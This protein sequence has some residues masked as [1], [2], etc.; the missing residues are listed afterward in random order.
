MG[1]Q[2]AGGASRMVNGRPRP[3]DEKIGSA[4]SLSR[5]QYKSGGHSIDAALQKGYSEITSMCNKLDLNKSV[6]SKACEIF[7]KV[8][9][10]KVANKKLK[11]NPE[12]VIAA[13]V[14]VACLIKDVPRTFKEFGRGVTSEQVRDRT[15]QTNMTSATETNNHA[16]SSLA[17]RD[18]RSERPIP[19]C[20]RCPESGL[21]PDFKTLNHVIDYF[22]AGD[23]ERDGQGSQAHQGNRQRPDGGDYRSGQGQGHF[24][25]HLHSH[26]GL[27]RGDRF[28]Q[29]RAPSLAS[30]CA[31]MRASHLSFSA[32]SWPRARAHSFSPGSTRSSTL[33]CTLS[34][35][36]KK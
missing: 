7:K 32:A 2:I 24:A 5:S 30:Q 25:A 15:T 16:T 13:C 12:C 10:E 17:P 4:A 14:Y 23:Q 36:R 35:R 31:P 28:H 18:A 11:R 19:I 9:E 34:R 22:R 3:G 6:V 21:C 1:T 20:S 33:R 26:Q 27:K 29:L 8:E